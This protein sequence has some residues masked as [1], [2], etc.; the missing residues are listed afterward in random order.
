MR[1][2]PT[3]AAV[4]ACADGWD[5]IIIIIETIQRRFQIMW[6]GI[7]C[8]LSKIAGTVPYLLDYLWERCQFDCLS[9]SRFSGKKNT[10][11]LKSCAKIK[12][13]D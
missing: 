10:N 13:L 8:S 9:T 12:H 2:S 1:W 6:A 7:K 3:T 11:L 5:I 4:L